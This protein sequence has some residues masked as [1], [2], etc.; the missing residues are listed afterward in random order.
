[1]C[2]TARNSIH[3]SHALCSLDYKHSEMDVYFHNDLQG[4]GS[5]HSSFYSF[6]NYG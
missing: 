1:M 2:M 4:E 3:I 6:D 5:L